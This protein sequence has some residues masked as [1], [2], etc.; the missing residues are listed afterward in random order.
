M[1]CIPTCEPYGRQHLPTSA[2]TV[3]L[4][5][6]PCAPQP[7]RTIYLGADALLAAGQRGWT[8][9]G[10]PIGPD[11]DHVQDPS[12]RHGVGC[13]SKI[14]GGRAKW[15]FQGE[16]FTLWSPMGPD[17][18]DIEVF[19]DGQRLGVCSLRADQPVQSAPIM[20][21]SGLPPGRHTVVLRA[22]KGTM[23]VDCLE[24][25]SGSAT[26]RNPD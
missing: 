23:V 6:V 19:Y 2:A 14:E 4:F 18:G 12:F 3:H 1:G 15:N 8:D 16:G 26:Q 25:L 5:P 24:A 11:W 7:H 9:T 17:L 10:N 21:R 22:I 20:E 13:R